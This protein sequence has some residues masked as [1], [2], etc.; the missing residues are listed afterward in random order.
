VRNL[1]THCKQ[2]QARC[3]STRSVESCEESRHPDWQP[4]PDGCFSTRSVESCEESDGDDTTAAI[5]QVSVLALSSR[6][7]NQYAIVALVAFVQSFSTRSVESC[8]ESRE[9]Q[10]YIWAVTSCF[11]TRSVESCEESLS[12]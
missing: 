4:P 10:G 8:E 11:S 5:E 12:I 3:F 1:W 2:K 6:V 7:R 9:R